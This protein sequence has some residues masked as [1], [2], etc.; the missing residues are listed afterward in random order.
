MSNGTPEGSQPI[1]QELD[2]IARVASAMVDG[3]LCQ[4]IVTARALSF[5]FK[6]DPN[7]PFLAGDNYDVNDTEFN[8]TKKTLIRLARLAPFPC[9]VNLW[10]P[11][12]G[13]PGKIQAVVRN[14]NELSQFWSFGAL[15]QDAIPPMQ[16]VLDSGQRVTVKNKPGWISVLAPVY[17]SLGDVAGLVEVVTRIGTASG[18]G[19]G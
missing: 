13:H 15:Y 19:T 5:L 3:D 17:N 12:D 8:A 10:M 2:H 9:D 4:R 18:T 14:V 1:E 7:D 16:A 6:T 11:I